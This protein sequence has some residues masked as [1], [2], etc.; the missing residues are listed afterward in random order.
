[1]PADQVRE[2]AVAFFREVGETTEALGVRLC[3]EPNPEEYG[4]DFVTRSREALELVE[5]V[6]SPGFGLHLD[7]AALHLSGES[8]GEALPPAASRLR[9]FHASEPWLASFAEPEVDHAAMARSL[10]AVGYRG[11]VSIEMRP[12]ETALDSVAEA[13]R[14]VSRSYGPVVSQEDV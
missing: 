4:C 9:H 13:V 2:S 7:A 14:R 3:I 5:A 11:W 6:D 8:P 1:M 10:A 12:T